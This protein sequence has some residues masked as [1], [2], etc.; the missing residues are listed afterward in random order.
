MNDWAYD[1]S[2]AFAVPLGLSHSINMFA[3]TAVLLG[4]GYGCGGGGGGGGGGKPPVVY[5]CNDHKDNDGDGLVDMADPGCTSLKDNSEYNAPPNTAPALSALPDQYL[6]IGS[7]L[8]DNLI[9]L[10][11]Y[12]SDAQDADNALVY[13]I[14]SQTNTTVA[15]CTIDSNR[16]VDCTVAGSGI[17]DITVHVTD[18]GGLTASDTFRLTVSSNIAPIAEA[19]GPYSGNEGAS[20]SFSGSGSDADGSIVSYAWD[21]GDGTNAAGQNVIHTYADNKTY[22]ATLTVT[23]N[24]GAVGTDITNAVISNL[25]PVVNLPNSITFLEDGSNN[26]NLASYVTDVA[27]DLPPASWVYSGNTNVLVNVSGGVATFTAKPNWYGSETVS[28]TATDKDGGSG[29]DSILVTVTPVDDA[30]VANNVSEVTPK[31]T[32][33]QVTLNCTDI[34]G[35]PLTYIKV[36]DPSHGSLGAIAGNKVT[37]TPNSTWSGVDSFTYKCSD[38]TVEGNAATASINVGLTNNA[39][40]ADNVSDLTDE[41]TAKQVTLNCTDIEGDPLTYIKVTN[42]AH[43]SLGAIAGNKVT[44][45]PSSNWNGSDSFTYKCYDGGLDSNVAT[46][47]MT[48]NPVN[49]APVIGNPT[50]T[51]S[52]EGSYLVGSIA[53]SDIDSPSV[54]CSLGNNGG[55][56]ELVINPDCT[57]SSSVALPYDRAG[58]YNVTVNANDGNGGTTSKTLPITVANLNRAPVFNSVNITK[59]NEGYALEGWA[60]CTDPDGDPV[61]YSRG[62][63]TLTQAQVASDGTI[64]SVALPAGIAGPY[65]LEVICS[66]G[67][68]SASSTKSFTVKDVT[69]PSAMNNLEAYDSVNKGEE[70]RLRWVSSGDDGAVGTPSYFVISYSANPILTEADWLS[71]TPL[72]SVT[73]T[74]PAGTQYDQ[75]FTVPAGTWYFGV[76]AVDEA[77]N[78]SPISN[79][80][81]ATIEDK[82]EFY[83]DRWLPTTS[84]YLTYPESVAMIQGEAGVNPSYAANL[85]AE[86]IQC[87]PAYPR[88]AA[89]LTQDLLDF[90]DGSSSNDELH[91]GFDPF[92]LDN[93]AIGTPSVVLY[94]A[95]NGMFIDDFANLPAQAVKN[96]H[97]TIRGF[98]I[99]HIKAHPADYGN[100]DPSHDPTWNDGS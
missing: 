99:D 32:A 56:L 29:L 18:T 47:S 38:G 27:A 2:S 98:L 94:F 72:A 75:F 55:L 19:N 67:S 48:V 62:A 90:T 78:E 10:F 68:L 57:V 43:G 22:T 96:I 30:P 42:P 49:D 88:N 85:A 89:G 71:A 14:T 63:S 91:S 73:A 26:L 60:S 93:D 15:N 59:A 58:T 37:Y 50:I 76:K 97:S 6:T 92:Y 51:T 3:L 5:Q 39:P 11:V 45:T 12:A 9:D 1:R 21:F 24:E 80:P 81:T 35:D 23:D 16:Y 77:G 28:F 46:V 52:I 54:T 34:E 13:T 84:I 83:V 20:V 74:G 31:N 65:S 41:D 33:K 61:T 82:A 66:D 17:S 25:N 87:N 69:A 40:L 8:N 53:V 36:T 86:M 100:L 4:Y 7:G 95:P 44:Y 64:S 70:A 79:S